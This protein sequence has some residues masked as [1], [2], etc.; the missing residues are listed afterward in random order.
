MAKSKS[1]AS[2]ADKDTR[3]GPKGHFNGL[4]LEYLKSRLPDFLEAVKQDNAGYWKRISWRAGEK[5]DV[6]ETMFI[7]ASVPPDDDLE[8]SEEDLEAKS[9]LFDLIYGVSCLSSHFLSYTCTNYPP[10]VSK[11]GII[12]EKTTKA[13]LVSG[14]RS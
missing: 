14:S 11:I 7:N 13:K 12:T 6:D 8:L 9:A 10:S 1:Q 2:A 4:R 5:G 3:P